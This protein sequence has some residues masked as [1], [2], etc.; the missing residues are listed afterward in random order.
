MRMTPRQKM[1]ISGTNAFVAFFNGLVDLNRISED[2]FEKIGEESAVF[3]GA[4]MG[5]A[6]F[7]PKEREI[8][9]VTHGS[10]VGKANNNEVNHHYLMDD[11]IDSSSKEL[12]VVN[13]SL[14]IEQIKQI[15]KMGK[16]LVEAIKKE[17]YTHFYLM[18]VQE[19]KS[20]VID[21]FAEA[22]AAIVDYYYYEQCFPPE[23]DP[24]SE[25]FV[26]K[27]TSIAT[28]K[29]IKGQYLD[30]GIT[31]HSR[32][33]RHFQ[34]EPIS[35]FGRCLLYMDSIDDPYY[36]PCNVPDIYN[37]SWLSLTQIVKALLVHYYLAFGSYKRLKLCRHCGSL[38][39][40]QRSG[41]KKYCG[42][43]CRKSFYILRNNLDKM[44]CLARQNKYVANRYDCMSQKDIPHLLNRDHCIL[45][46]EVKPGGKC[47][48]LIKLNQTYF[49]D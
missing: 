39:L 24:L 47:E 22:I 46:E 27:I 49:R 29:A 18:E 28:Q 8:I 45:C 25:D 38:L 20:V 40:E 13:F 19:E 4:F 1:L 44:R 5:E 10:S 37:N 6:L 3:L 43:A 30:F 9:I 21:G 35:S 11:K 34:V 2:D 14:N 41:R 12:V 7:D 26:R 32:V 42:D 16:D 36:T 33:I 48:T 23:D 31:L 15:Y 17:D